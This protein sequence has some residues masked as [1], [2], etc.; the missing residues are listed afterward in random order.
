[1]NSVDEALKLVEQHAKL[2]P[3]CRVPLGEAAELVLAEDVTSDINS[4]PYDKAMMDG[5]AIVSSDREPVR[6]VIEEI[7]AGEVPHRAV[8][9]GSVA[10]IMTGAPLPDGADAVVPH[11]ETELLDDGTVRFRHFDTPPGKNVMP[12]GTS[13]Q[14]GQIVLCD[15]AVLRP[16]EIAIL[17]EIGHAVVRV[18]PRPQVAVLPTGNELVSVGE[19]PSAR[20]RGPAMRCRGGRLRRR[21]RRS[22]RLAS[23]DRAR[24]RHRR[25]IALR[26]RFGRQ[27]RFGSRSA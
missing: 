2:L 17:A 3:A 8:T 19:R 23:A 9:P 13:L 12:L 22:R 25:I 1:M 15:G 10:R 7:A 6:P 5:Y 16:I 24:I 4:P 14:A 18:R 26:R 21:P 20:D 27:V 11:E